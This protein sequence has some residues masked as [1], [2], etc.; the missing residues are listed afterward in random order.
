MNKLFLG[1][2]FTL[3]TSSQLFASMTTLTPTPNDLQDLSHDDAYLWE[4]DAAVL[5]NKDI[6]STT[7]FI[8]NINNTEEPEVDDILF[9][10]LLN[11]TPEGNWTEI[12]SN[13]YST[14]FKADERGTRFTYDDD[15]DYDFPYTGTFGTVDNPYGSDYFVADYFDG[16]PLVTYSDNEDGTFNFSYE[17]SVEDLA[18]FQSYV[19]DG[20][21]VA[22]GF[23][24]DC[25]F[26]NSGVRLEVVPE[27]TMI[28]LLGLSLLSFGG[29]SATRFRRR[30]K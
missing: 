23:D 4:I 28:T 13:S 15:R 30:K 3:Y 6:Q 29:L 1:L 19:D 22:F 21:I 20:G 8:D 11:E 16:D 24:P 14:T 2:A 17:F 10:H 18:L 9:I 26:T 25:H 7:L 27:P 5:M 12:G